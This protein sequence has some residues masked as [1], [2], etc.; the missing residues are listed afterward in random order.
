L[1]GLEVISIAS[2]EG[3]MCDKEGHKKT[4]NIAGRRGGQGC[5]A[6]RV[7]AKVRKKRGTKLS[8]RPVEKRD[9]RLPQKKARKK[10]KEMPKRI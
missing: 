10:E 8:S 4:K 7:I 6:Q 3:T 2:E 1:R 9:S 5:R